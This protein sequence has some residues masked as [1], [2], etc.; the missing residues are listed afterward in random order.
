M[1][2]L[3]AAV[4]TILLCLPVCACGGKQ[5][6][7]E[8]DHNYGDSYGTKNHNVIRPET[9]KATEAVRREEETTGAA[10]ENP[11]RMY[12]HG[13]E[14][15]ELAVEA[16]MQMMTGVV[17]QEQIKRMF[18][19]RIWNDSEIVDDNYYAQYKEGI[20]E[21][22]AG[23]REEFGEDYRITWKISSVEMISENE[24]YTEEENQNIREWAGAD[25]KDVKSYY[26]TLSV[27]IKGNK[28]ELTTSADCYPVKI[29]EKWYVY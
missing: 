26:V 4:L 13:Y 6:D 20:E 28:G 17:S 14:S 23:Y 9:T 19:E 21:A 18:P 25:G 12:T 8:I 29:L 22:L 5:Y 16:Y 1:K 3:M 11:E 24:T 15:M 10:K 27:Q 2:R 7:Y